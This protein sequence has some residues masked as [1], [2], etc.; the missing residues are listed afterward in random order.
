MV[1]KIY[2][3]SISGGYDSGDLPAGRNWH[4]AFCATC[5]K[6]IMGKNYAVRLRTVT[7]S[8]MH[9]HMCAASQECIL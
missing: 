1:V 6:N 5:E 8:E 7:E 9:V 2:P 4:R 3:Y